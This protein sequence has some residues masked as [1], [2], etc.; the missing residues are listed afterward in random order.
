MAD[1]KEKQYVSDNA[2]LM[3]EWDWAENERDMYNPHKITLGNNIIKVH[4]MCDRGHHWQAT[5]YARNSLKTNCP[6]CSGRYAT[7]ETSLATT[8]PGLAGQWDYSKNGDITPEQ[9]KQF[10][11][12]DA[13]WICEKGHSWR[14]KVSDRSNGNGCPICMNETHSSFPEQ[15]LFYYI[16]QAIPSAL[17]RHKHNNRFEADIFLPEHGIAIEYDGEYFHREND[18][19]SKKEQYFF[20]NNIVLIRL[21][22]GAVTQLGEKRSI[23]GVKR[24]PSLDDLSNAFRQLFAFLHSNYDL[25]LL[26][27]VNVERDTCFIL[28]QFLQTQKENSIGE[29]LQL[30]SEW[31]YDKNGDVQPSLVSR[32]S[33]RSFWWKCSRGHSWKAIC[34]NR[35]QG[36]G[37]PFCAGKKVLAGDNDLATT[38][39]HL[40]QKWSEQNII[41][42]TEITAGS[43]RKVWWVCE[44]GHEFEAS[45]AHIVRGRDCP[46][47]CGK[48][49]LI[50][51][52]DFA[53]RYPWLLEEWDFEKNVME[54]T[55][56]TAGTTR[57]ASWICSKC[58][59]GWS[60]SVLSRSR[61]SGCPRCGREAAQRANREKAIQEQGTLFD[62]HPELMVEWDWEKNTQLNPKELS[63]GSSEKAWWVC[64]I[65]GRSWCTQIRV[66]TKKG[67]GCQSCANK[68]QTSLSKQD[69]RIIVK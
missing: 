37:C 66:R 59:F 5:V 48:K 55:E 33:N 41:K 42:P 19:D 52:N 13:W 57:A 4:W 40:V 27:D 16:K 50:G 26:E 36:R 54:P 53:S 62:K 45:P 69:R 11:H 51:Y 68:S 24:N 15:A 61:G 43:D 44:K 3:A 63:A 9:V 65:C 58:G 17:N 7:P 23:L 67:C 6:Y 31:D 8:N 25:S 10:S 56:I 49:V 32:N 38:H 64:S 20:E 12:Y 21:K 35:A 30:A 60:A 34:N 28:S 22:E 29:D 46:Y 39:P 47:C 14:A 1:K 2:Q 18:N